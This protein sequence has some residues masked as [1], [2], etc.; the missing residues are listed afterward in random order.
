MLKLGFDV[1]E[2]T[3]QRYLP[4]KPQRTTRQR[5]KTFLKNH[6][7]E[8]ISLDF[9]VVPTVTFKLLHVLVFLS[10]DRRKIMH[11]NV[12]D[13]P[14]SEWATQQLRNAFCDEEAPKFLVRD[15]DG[16]FGEDFSNC[17]SAL[18]IRPILT[19]YRSPWQN[20]HVE[21]VIGSI[22]R[23]CLDHMIIAN[24]TH[25]RGILQSY[26]HY[27]NTQR[28][29][30]GVNKDSPEPRRVQAHGEIHKVAV[31]NRLHHF[32]FRKAA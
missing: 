11:F 25:L 3:V 13:H 23:E 19:A 9:F 28:T 7:A 24:E 27:Y 15:R 29:H 18:G 6:S 17:V 26:V 22:R 21:R 31:A 14:T 12:T 5:W 16:K 1:S 20:G 30:L 2:S 8:I 32:Y 4:R 10:H